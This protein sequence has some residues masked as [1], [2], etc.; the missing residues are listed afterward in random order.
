M[1]NVPFASDVVGLIAVLW[2]T[3]F[4]LFVLKWHWG[5]VWVV[6]LGYLT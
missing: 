3:C 5:L 1:G 6:K 4:V 2:P